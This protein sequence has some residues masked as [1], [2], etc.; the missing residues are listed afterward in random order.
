MSEHPLAVQNGT[1]FQW[2]KARAD[3]AVLL[4]ENDLSDQAIAER[5]GV[6]RMTLFRWRQHPEFAAR[7][8][9]HVA[10]FEA[11]T[12]RYEIAKRRRRVAALQGRWDKLHAI[13]EQRAERYGGAAPGSD[14]GLLVRQ[15]KSI[16][17]GTSKLGDPEYETVEDWAL[18][19]TLLKELREHEKQAAQ[20]VGQ[21][22]EKQEPGGEGI[23]RVYVGV[24]VEVV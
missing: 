18:D 13:I 12:L 21:W 3:A 17:S 24:R 20:E 19:A 14:T 5:V 8:A 23:Q 6:G 1:G 10:E 16:R 2:T 4:A 7:I 9:E 22:D 15:Y 11:A